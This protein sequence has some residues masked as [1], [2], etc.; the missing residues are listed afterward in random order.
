[1]NER[2]SAVP[3]QV[4]AR[5]GS[6]LVNQIAV[7]ALVLS[8]LGII[9][10][11]RVLGYTILDAHV[12]RM[13]ADGTVPVEVD[14]A[15]KGMPNLP[16]VE[17]LL[18]E[19]HALAEDESV[20]AFHI[21]AR[22]A[23]I[24]E[25][26]FL[27]TGVPAFGGLGFT[28]QPQ[29]SRLEGGDPGVPSTPDPG[30]T[31][32]QSGPTW[33]ENAYLRL[34]VDPDTGRLHLLDK[35]NDRLYKDLNHFVDGGDVGD[36][37]NYSPPLEDRLVDASA[38]PSHLETVE[39][40]PVRATL[41]V[42]KTYRLP[43]SC[44][45][46]RL[47]RSGQEVDCE[48]VTDVSL[49]AGSRRVE[50]RCSVENTARDH[51]LR[52]EFPVPFLCSKAD[53]EGTFGVIRRPATHPEP[54]PGERPW[55]E[56][57]ESPVNT[58][59]QKRFVDLN[60]GKRGLAVLNRGLPE[61]EIVH[62]STGSGSALALTLL[63]CTEWLSRDDLRTRRGHAGPHLYTPD[64]QGIGQQTFEYALVPHAGT[65]ESEQAF[66]LREAQAYEAPC[67]A[68][69]TDPHAGGSL[70]SAWSFLRVEPATVTV[71]A[72][73]RS[74]AGDGLIVRLFNPLA[75]ETLAEVT[76]SSPIKSVE[77]V[78]LAEDPVRAETSAPLARILSTGVRTSLRGGEIQT[79]R[80]SMVTE[81][82]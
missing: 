25:F 67:R 42:R 2:G 15:E 26:L 35:V 61:Y 4:L 48:I 41:R 63:R 49:E 12:G 17:R 54:G 24:T 8:M 11:G 78:N 81:D 31:R 1:V 18:D 59:A 50:L 55:S 20:T 16:A 65:W 9:S 74:T 7:K 36:L 53:A 19:V 60:D 68:V 66:I 58:Y 39:S 22:E 29:S 76:L 62:S 72:V 27:A 6:E 28:L 37:Y 5:Q 32:L 40:G 38:A 82:F 73:T 79:L 13:E 46:D 69:V 75:E 57:A 44:S 30:E 80:F 51:R 47:T 64:A 21:V 14:V 10:G 23:P 52:V 43:A 45:P 3:T 34:D 70:P 33:L 71:S 77:R 56:W